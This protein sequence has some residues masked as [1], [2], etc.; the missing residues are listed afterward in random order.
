MYFY[1]C[2]EFFFFFLNMYFY[3][4]KSFQNIDKGSNRGS[5]D[6]IYSINSTLSARI[7]LFYFY[8]I[9]NGIT[10]TVNVLVISC[11]KIRE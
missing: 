9:T 10:V 6:Q 7:S 2:L 5:R 4:L 11:T 1:S 3:Q 8:R